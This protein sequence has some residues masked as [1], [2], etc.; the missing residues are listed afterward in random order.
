MYIRIMKT[1]EAFE[2]LI[3]HRGWHK[4]L[5]ITDATAWSLKHNFKNGTITI[6]KMEEI[7]NK[8]GFK[9]I[10]EKLWAK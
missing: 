2:Q 8:A 1:R 4:D 6:D 10:Q 7:L 5:D 9:I 3:M